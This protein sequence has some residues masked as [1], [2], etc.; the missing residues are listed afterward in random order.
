MSGRSIWIKVTSTWPWHF[1]KTTKH[2]E[3]KSSGN[4]LNTFS[5]KNSESYQIPFC[6]SLRANR[7]RFK[8]GLQQLMPE[9]SVSIFSYLYSK[10]SL[11][12]TCFLNKFEHVIKQKRKQWMCLHFF[13]WG[14]EMSVVLL[15]YL[16]LS[17]FSAW[18]GI[19]KKNHQNEKK[20]EICTCL[21]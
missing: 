20:Q 15:H 4:K 6:F 7:R 1:V 19:I 9:L 17:D 10:Q 2:K 3:M 12:W 13:S 16:R 5:M 11:V 18:E 14:P 8:I 21:F